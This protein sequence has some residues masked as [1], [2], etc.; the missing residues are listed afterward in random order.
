M[1]TKQEPLWIKRLVALGAC[2]DAIE[3]AR[4]QPDLAT[5]WA[6]C[7]RGD[8]ML[9]FA[10]R[11]LPKDAHVTERRSRER[12]RLVRAALACAQLAWPLVRVRD[13]A[14]VQA[15][16][17]AIQQ[18]CDGNAPL[19]K[20]RAAADVVNAAAASA[21][22]AAVLATYYAA[23]IAYALYATNAAAA[24]FTV[25]RTSVPAMCADI[26]RQHYPAPPE[27]P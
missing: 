23:Y 2:G 19:S 16:Y 15:C 14:V 24:A 8:R 20:V 10:G 6:V 9:W 25:A 13:Q 18:W 27:W 26:V 1:T 21:A 17:E 22:Y 4:T 5:A 3:W 12:V 11:V 7:D